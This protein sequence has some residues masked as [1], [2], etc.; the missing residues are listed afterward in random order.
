MAQEQ[1]HRMV[2]A[3]IAGK[4]VIVGVAIQSPT[5]Q[6]WSLPAPNRHHHLFPV[7]CDATGMKFVPSSWQQGFVTN[8]GQ[9]V[10]RIPARVI[11]HEAGQL[12]PRAS[13]RVELFSEDV[14]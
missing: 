12:L 2:G 8:D 14:W 4:P 1:A 9:F 7:I 13:K 11:A 3:P 10:G 5:G 6:V